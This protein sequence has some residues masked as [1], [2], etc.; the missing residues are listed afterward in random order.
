MGWPPLSNVPPVRLTMPA[1]ASNPW[2]TSSLLPV[3][4]R[5]KPPDWIQERAAEE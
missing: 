1:L 5:T 2:V 3:P 4:A